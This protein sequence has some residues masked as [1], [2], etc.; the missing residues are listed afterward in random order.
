MAYVYLADRSICPA[1]GQKCD[2]SKPP[3]FAA[4]VMPAVRAFDYVNRTGT[5]IPRLKETLDLI[6]A[7]EPTPAGQPLRPFEIFN[8]KK[9]VPI[10]AYLKAHPRPDLLSSMNECAGLASAHTATVLA[11]SF[12]SRVLA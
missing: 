1:A 11:I 7:R 5:P 8:G 3:R 12:C 4:E 2:W 9:L 6:F 10:Y